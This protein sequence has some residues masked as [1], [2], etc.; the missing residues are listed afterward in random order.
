MTYAVILLTLYT[1]P[2]SASIGTGTTSFGILFHC[3]FHSHGK[4]L[5]VNSATCWVRPKCMVQ[6]WSWGEVVSRGNL[7]TW[8]F[9]RVSSLIPQISISISRGSNEVCWRVAVCGWLL[10]GNNKQELK[11][12]VI[13]EERSIFSEVIVSV[14]VKRS[15]YEQLCNPEW[16]PRQSC[17]NLQM[18]KHCVW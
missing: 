3:P 10:I 17:I 16:L 5:T 2:L 9:V 7:S 13:Q 1:Y 11:Y 6:H 8:N 14:I 12:R 18:K 15:S 4:K